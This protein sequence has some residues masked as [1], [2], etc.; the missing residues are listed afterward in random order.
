MG[1]RSRQRS[2]IRYAVTKDALILP[3]A[4]V[5][6]LLMGQS[7]AN[8][9]LKHHLQEEQR[10]TH[11]AMKDAPIKPS[12]DGS[13]YAMGQKLLVKLAIMRDAQTLQRTWEGSVTGIIGNVG[14][15]A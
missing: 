12:K 1:K 13:V 3:V 4:E 7:L 2:L 11:A 9:R 15:F 6:V 10:A 5:S 14:Q 8:N